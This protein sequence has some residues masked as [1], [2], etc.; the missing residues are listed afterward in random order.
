MHV[1]IS[2]C[3]PGCPGSGSVDHKS[4]FKVRG[5]PASA[6]QKSVRPKPSHT[7]GNSSVGNYLPCGC[8]EEEGPVRATNGVIALVKEDALFPA[9]FVSLRGQ[10]P[11]KVLSPKT[12]A[13]IFPDTVCWKL[14]LDFLASRVVI[15]IFLVLMNL[16]ILIQKQ[17]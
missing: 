5:P 7:L 9:S 6:S 17:E 16:A 8:Y 15:N 1:G 11:S 13:D 2:P 14:T 4:C 10:H 3:S 12:R